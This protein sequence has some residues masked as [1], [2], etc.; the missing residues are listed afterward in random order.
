MEQEFC[1]SIP[2]TT[3]SVPAHQEFLD[4]WLRF[5]THIGHAET[6]Y[7]YYDEYLTWLAQDENRY[8]I[9]GG[10]NYELAIPNIQKFKYLR[11]QSMPPEEQWIDLV[12]Q[13]HLDPYRHLIY[14][15]GNHEMGRILDTN[16]FFDPLE[17]ETRK[18]SIPYSR[19]NTYFMLTIQGIDDEDKIV[20]KQQYLFYLSHGRSGAREAE[21]PLKELIRKGIGAEAD[22]VIVGHTHHNFSAPFY[23]NKIRKMADK[24]FLTTRKIFGVRAGAFLNNP[25]YVMNDRPRP[26]VRGNQILRLGVLEKD[27]S[28]YQNLHEWRKRNK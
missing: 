12:E 3:I 28:S 14:V 8:D 4:I 5:D 19:T 21:F 13:L 7:P 24:F 9:W 15:T 23:V 2:M 20:S 26:L 22:I 6:D 18:L 1:E 16:H 10:D 11:T 25:A 17:E 27:I